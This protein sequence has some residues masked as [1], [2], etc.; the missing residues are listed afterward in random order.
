MQAVK[1]T[2]G[3]F[4]GVYDAISEQGKSYDYT[5]PIAEQLGGNVATVLPPPAQD[6]RLASVK[7]GSIFGINE[8]THKIWGG[9]VTKALESGQLKCVPEPLVVG[10]GLEAVQKGLD[11]NKAGV[12][13]KKVVIEL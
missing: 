7:S 2:G 9:Y 3:A 13:A 5:F 1:K 8:F 12:S 4:A 10:K 6:A 11:T